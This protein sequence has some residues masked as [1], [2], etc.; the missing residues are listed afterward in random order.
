MYFLL[1]CTKN[2]TSTHFEE[3]VA[4]SGGHAF[5]DKGQGTHFKEL[6]LLQAVN[7]GRTIQIRTGHVSQEI[8]QVEIGHIFPS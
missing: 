3:D 5:Q 4:A 1:S 8:V 6:H 7:T 2:E